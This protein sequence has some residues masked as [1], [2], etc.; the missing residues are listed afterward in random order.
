MTARVLVAG[1]GNIFLADDGFGS[2]VARRLL[3]EDAAGA[4]PNGSRA[5]TPWSSWTRC[6]RWTE[7]RRRARCGFWR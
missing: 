7:R 1:V 5:T 3:Q 6:R 4:L 2:E